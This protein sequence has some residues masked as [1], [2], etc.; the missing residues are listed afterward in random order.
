MTATA[1]RGDRVYRLATGACAASIPMLLAFIAWVLATAAWPAF[2]RF[3]AGFLTTGTWD[4][5][6]DAY[7]VGPALLGT[8]VTAGLALAVA[9]P[10]AVAVAVYS[11]ELAPRVLRTPLAFLIDLLAGIP[12]VVYGLWGIGVVVPALRDDVGPF[13]R[14][15]LHLGG[16]PLF[17]GPSFGPSVLAGAAV[18]A[19]MILPFVAAVTRE[20]LL[21]VPRAQREAAF[22]LGATRWETVIDVVL[23]YARGG[24]IGAVMLGLGR[25]LGETIAVA[26]VIGGQHAFA[27]SLLAPGYTLA[28][29]AANEFAEASDELHVAALMAAAATL[30]ALTLVVNAVARWLVGRVAR[31]GE[32]T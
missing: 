19:T 24:V 26:L 11:A 7:A 31:R 4:P 6:R 30:F 22:A 15:T 17:A 10:L 3:G 16:L 25:A 12:S 2:A 29:L 27:S 14:G 21:A 20:V 32:A 8:L 28:S 13:L 23:P 1:R 5:V 9:A 18:L